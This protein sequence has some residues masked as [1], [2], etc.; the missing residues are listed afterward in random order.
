MKK[1]PAS[2][3]IMA[4]LTTLGFIR[5]SVSLALTCSGNTFSFVSFSD[6]YMMGAGS[7]LGE[8]VFGKMFGLDPNVAMIIANGDETDIRTARETVD[9]HLGSH[10]D[11][12]AP[13]FPFFTALGNHNLDGEDTSLSWYTSTYANNWETN[14]AGSRLALQ[15][16]G[17]TNFRRGPL[18]VLKSSG[19]ANFA[20]GSVYSFDYRNAH[21]VVINNYENIIDD[22]A[23]GA[24][25]V[26]GAS[27]NNLENSQLD[28]LKADL[29]GTAKSIK[30]VFSHVGLVAPGP[31]SN[32]GIPGCVQ[33]S[34]HVGPFH[35]SELAKVLSDANV[36]AV[37]RG[38]DHCPSRTL[39]DG[40]GAK[41]FERDY[42][43]AYN[44]STGRP[45]GNPALWQGLLGPGKVWQVDDGSVYNNMGFFT[46]TKVTDSSVTF[47]TYRFD[48]PSGALSLW[49]SFTIPVSGAAVDTTPPAAPRGL[50]LR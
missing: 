24:W 1:T 29:Q 39:V 45:Y 13:E 44:D 27:V 46:L 8:Q 2:I 32:S 49:D 33:Y 10:L 25:D 47:E 23:A 7:G 31:Y 21:F 17:L 37:Y 30:F 22:A 38:H 4:L 16:P 20:N 35:T 3:V 18:Q 19:T 36:T 40:N 28:W 48:S 14:A 12:G 34:D 41:V 50:A 11:C 26:N 6:D 5:P 9:Y 42:M 43:D 15:L